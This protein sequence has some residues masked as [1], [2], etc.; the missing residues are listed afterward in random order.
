MTI[1]F[2]SRVTGEYDVYKNNDTGVYAVNGD[3]DNS[4]GSWLQPNNKKFGH[5]SYHISADSQWQN[6]SN[7]QVREAAGPRYRQTQARFQTDS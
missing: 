5:E 1:T 6:E 7:S 2:N 4:M 3:V